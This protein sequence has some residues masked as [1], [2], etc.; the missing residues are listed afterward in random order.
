[1][2]A[3]FAGIRGLLINRKE[4]V[5]AGTSPAMTIHGNMRLPIVKM[6]R[7]SRREMARFPA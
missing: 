2:P 6:P 4:D 1:M 7:A 3:L 5:D